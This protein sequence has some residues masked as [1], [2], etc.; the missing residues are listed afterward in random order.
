[1]SVA[2]C[3][4]DTASWYSSWARGTTSPLDSGNFNVVSG[5]TDRV[6]LAF[7]AFDTSLTVTGVVINPTGT[8][9]AMSFIGSKDGDGGQRIEV[10]GILNPSAFITGVIRVTFT[11]SGEMTVGGAV[12]KGVDQGTL[13]ASVVFS[14]DKGTGTSASIAMS[15]A[16]GDATVS[17]MV[18]DKVRSTSNPGGVQ[19][20]IEITNV[21]YTA[22]MGYTLSSGA[23]D[24]H[25]WTLSGSATWAIGAVRIKATG[26]VSGGQAPRSAFYFATNW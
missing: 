17:A 22:A 20:T 13:A 23:S 15:T 16:S 9:E 2:I 24:S 4:T 8:N 1:M 5:D 19:T 6:A 7:L 3:T 11:G 25:A 10:W 21:N 14:S 12:F 18:G 26:T